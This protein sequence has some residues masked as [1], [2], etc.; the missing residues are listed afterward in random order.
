MAGLE[1]WGP[2]GG[3]RIVELLDD[4][5]VVGKADDAD[6][7]LTD[8]S[9]VSAA[10]AMVELIGQRWYVKDLDSRN[11]TTVNKDRILG[12]RALRDRDELV[13][14]K[15]RVVY[16]AQQARR[17]PT[18][19]VIAPAPKLTKRQHE[20]VVA[21]CRPLLSGDPFTPPT[22]VREMAQ[23]LYVTVA[24]VRENLSRLYLLFDV[25]LEGDR[26]V[27][28]A[29]EAVRRGAVTAKDIEDADKQAGRSR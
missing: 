25:P 24:A 4:R 28:L 26:R 2:K 14:G 17:D 23:E 29:N 8:D 7:V 10:H 6:I 21:L 13:L 27:Q 1:I 5:Y 3:R 12:E 19:D 11:G 15:T 22:P 16:F 20:V 18:T 9:T